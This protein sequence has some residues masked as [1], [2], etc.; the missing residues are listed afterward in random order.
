MSPIIVSPWAGAVG[1]AAALSVAAIMSFIASAGISLPPI[2]TSVP[3]IMRTI[4]YKKPFPVTRI[5]MMSPAFDTVQSYIV[6]TVVCACEFAEQKLAK[7][8][9][10]MSYFAASLIFSVAS[11]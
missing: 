4:L 3:A 9:S 6:R 2:F 11:G 8:C 1:P 10:P 5:V 7:E